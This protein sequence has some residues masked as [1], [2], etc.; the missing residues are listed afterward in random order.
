MSRL[1]HS[2][3]RDALRAYLA[4]FIST[5]IFVFATVGS[6]MSQPYS[7]TGPPPCLTSVALASAFSLAAAV[8]VSGMA[9]GGHVNPAVT[10]GMAVGGHISVPMS[11]FYWISQLLGSVTACL[12]LKLCTVTQNMPV[13]GNLP[14]DMTGFGASILEGVMTF[15]LVYMV[16]AGGDTRRGLLGSIGPLMIGLVV[17]AN[18]LASAAFTGGSMNPALSFGAGIVGGS[19]KNQAVYWIGPLIGAALAGILYDNVVFPVQ[20]A[21]APDGDEIEL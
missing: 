4:E 2:I 12:L 16:Y 9:S 19:F 5:F 15:I 11:I 21:T 6:A 13:H 3:K 7:Q 8:Y 17:G 14:E 20:M 10:F 1:E 18:M